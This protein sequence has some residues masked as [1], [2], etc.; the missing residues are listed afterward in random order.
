MTNSAVIM[1]AGKGTRMFSKKPKVMHRLLGRPMIGYALDAI[2]KVT[3]N[4]PVV[5]VGYGA[6]EVRQ[7][8]G[9]D[10]LFAIQ[11]EQ[12]GTGHA[13]QQ[14]EGLLHGKVDEVLVL[15]ADMPL[16]R[17]STLKNLVALQKDHAGPVTMITVNSS[18]AWGFG[19]VE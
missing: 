3:D 14:A 9:D 6:E 13:V 12:L 4:K 10:A 7:Y 5:V 11:E 1:A 16:L 15:A 19:R 8:V 18:E 2:Q 17:D